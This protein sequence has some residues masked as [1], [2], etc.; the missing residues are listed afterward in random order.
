MR[1]F[2]LG[3]DASLHAGYPL[4]ADMGKCLVAW[5]NTFSTE[6]QHRLCLDQIVGV[7]GALDNFEPILADLMTC[8]PASGAEALGAA[9]P[10][11]L[12]NLK[13]AI[14]DHFD[15]LRSAS[16]SVFMLL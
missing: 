11:V 12:T 1:V 13:E 10:Y 4:A 14:R 5:I 3:A 16:S 6:H 8:P 15:S 2:A 7:Y 9:R